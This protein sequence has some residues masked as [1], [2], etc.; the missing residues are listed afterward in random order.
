MRVSYT[1][2]KSEIETLRTQTEIIVTEEN[3]Q[4]TR[5]INSKITTIELEGDLTVSQL[6]KLVALED[7]IFALVA[8]NQ[9]EEK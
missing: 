5:L 2:Y 4:L 1:E 9:R 3:T 7:T 6:Q 8:T